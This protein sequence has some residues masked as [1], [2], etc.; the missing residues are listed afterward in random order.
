MNVTPLDAYSDGTLFRGV[1]DWYPEPRI[2]TTVPTTTPTI[3]PPVIYDDTSL[4]PTETPT[5]SPIT[6]RIPP[7]APTIHYTSPFIHIDSSDDDT[8]DTPLSPTHKIPPV[9]VAPPTV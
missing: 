5:I 1:I 3:D 6:S 7:T 8:P 2:P 9:E 4:I